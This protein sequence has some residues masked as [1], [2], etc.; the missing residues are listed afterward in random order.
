[1]AHSSLVGID[2]VAI[3]PAGRDIAAL[4]PSDSS[5]SGSDMAGIDEPELNDAAEP[6]DFVLRNEGHRGVI[7][8]GEVHGSR[9]DSGGTGEGRGAGE[10]VGG[11]DG[12]DISVDRV[13]S[14]DDGAEGDAAS[15]IDLAEVGSSPAGDTEGPDDDDDDEEADE[16]DEPDAVEESA[17]NMTEEDDVAVD[18]E[19]DPDSGIEDVPVTPAKNGA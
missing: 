2:R 17:P 18:G 7:P 10:D 4:G 12:N 11:R 9:S 8:S 19:G 3:E 15:D 13:F 1:M 6:V 16:A 14:A 5:D